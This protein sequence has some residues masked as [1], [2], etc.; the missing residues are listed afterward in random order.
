MFDLPDDE[1]G[2]QIGRGTLDRLLYSILAMHM[3]DIG[4]TYASCSISVAY[5]SR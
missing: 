5:T 1:N 2:D 3:L 4:V